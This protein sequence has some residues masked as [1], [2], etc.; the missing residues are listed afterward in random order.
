MPKNPKR[1]HLGSLNVFYKPKTSKKWKGVPFDKIRKLP[2]L[3][4]LN[5]DERVRLN[6]ERDSNVLKILGSLS[7]QTPDVVHFHT[8][9]LDFYRSVK[10]NGLGGFLK[11]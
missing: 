4:V 5:V 10:S 11:K 3:F 7:S 2:H 8:F 9:Y 1:G 6:R